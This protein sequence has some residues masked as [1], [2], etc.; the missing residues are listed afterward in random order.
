MYEHN[1]PRPAYVR[2]EK[3]PLEQR[4]EAGNVLYVD[5]DYAIITPPG[6]PN[7][8]EKLVKEW[9]PILRKQV[10]DGMFPGAW[11]TE[12]EDAYR[13]WA[14]DQEPI[15]NGT[16]VRNWPSVS[17]AEA[18]NLTL[19]G[20]VAVEDVADMNAEVMQRLGMG[21][22]SLKQRAKD[23]LAAKTDLQPLVARLDAMQGQLN[24]KD[25]R[26]GELESKLQAMAHNGVQG[27]VAAPAPIAPLD[28]RLEEAR[29]RVNTVSDAQEA[30]TA[31]DDALSELE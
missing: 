15:V 20:L 21:A 30:N 24:L 16:D 12:Y 18:K 13:R 4:D 27:A 5:A 26:I 7:G 1:R 19:L 17:P 25:V 10:K 14:N 2:F 6:S 29:A 31:V 3:R 8:T 9:L 23:F 11:L 28:Q 22:V